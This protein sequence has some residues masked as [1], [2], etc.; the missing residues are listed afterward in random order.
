MADTSSSSTSASMPATSSFSAPTLDTDPRTPLHAR[1]TM[2][3]APPTP[4]ASDRL[5]FDGFAENLPLI[6]PSSNLPPL[7]FPS[8]IPNPTYSHP[9]LGVNIQT[10]VKFQVNVADVNFS[11]WR[12]I[13][14]LLLTMYSVMDHVTEGA[15]PRDPDAGW[16][17]VDIHLSLWFMTTLTEDLHRLVQGSDGSALSTWTRLHNFF[18]NNQ[19]SRYLYLSKAF[20]NTPRGDMTVATYASKLQSIADD[21][22]AIGRP[23]DD[24]DLALQFLDGLG[25]GYKLQ[26]EILKGNLPSFADCCSRIQL[27]EIDN[28][29]APAQVYAAHGH[30]GGSG[31]AHH[32][33]NHSNS[34]SRAPGVSPNYRGNN[35]IP[36]YRPGGGSGGSPQQDGRGRGRGYP[37][38]HGGATPN[39]GRG[40]DYGGRGRGSTSQEPW[41]GYFAPMGA[42]FPP[43]RSPWSASWTAPNAAG[44]LGSRPG[45]HSQAYHAVPS[46]PSSSS[47]PAYAAP[48]PS[49]TRTTPAACPSTSPTPHATPPWTLTTSSSPTVRV[50]S[51]QSPRGPP[52]SPAAPPSHCD[53]SAPQPTSPNHTSPHH[54]ALPPNAIS[55]EPPAN[56][57]PMVTRDWAGC[58]DTRKSTSRYCVFLGSNLVS[59]SSRRQNTVSRSSAEAEYRAV[60]NCIAESCW[61]RQLLCEL[62]HPPTRATV[63][64][65]DNISA[66]YMSSNPVQ[67]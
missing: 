54:P 63:V 48:A 41:V 35:P 45:P 16:R 46:G 29:D 65:C 39:T 38:G 3:R 22:D 23:V 31:S 28:D 36:G 43:A 19:T 12:Q 8:Q 32:G 33:G 7:I 67:H 56:H 51:S 11:K 24:R 25:K 40:F 60:A 14:K 49:A 50:P 15:A 17:A 57:H 55:V 37:G 34:A 53:L 21:L 64:Y 44:V 5:N 20:R 13:L 4:H 1:P 58:P 47:S 10:Y 42:P 27:A 66:M 9:I 26:A 6:Q 30:P 18:L 59:W 61:L 2:P 52:A 62:H